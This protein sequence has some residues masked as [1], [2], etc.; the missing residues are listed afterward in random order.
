MAGGSLRIGIKDRYGNTS[1]VRFYGQVQRE[2][3][4]AASPSGLIA[5]TVVMHAS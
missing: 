1:A 5:A 4:A 2:R 3:H